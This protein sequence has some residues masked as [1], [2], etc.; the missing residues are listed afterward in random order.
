MAQTQVVYLLQCFGIALCIWHKKIQQNNIIT[1]YMP[2]NS[3]IGSCVS[4][5]S[6]VLRYS[7]RQL[8]T[9]LTKKGIYIWD[10]LSCGMWNHV[11]GRWVPVLRQFKWRKFN[12]HRLPI[13]EYE[14]TTLSRKVGL[15]TPSDAIPCPKRTQT[16]T[17]SLRKPKSYTR[18][19][20]TAIRKEAPLMVISCCDIKTQR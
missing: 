18:S 12:K 9:L 5:L 20:T 4:F 3:W 11:T 2:Q 7:A 14:A 6:K 15:R 13:L 17:A 10:L 1:S 16:S 8:T 19:F